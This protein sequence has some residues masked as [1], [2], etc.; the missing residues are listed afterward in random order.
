MAA[1]LAGRADADLDPVTP[2]HPVY[3]PTPAYWPHPAILNAKALDILSPNDEPG[4]RIDR[5]TGHIHGL[6]I[7]NPTKLLGTIY[8][9]VPMPGPAER[10]EAMVQAFQENLTYG[11]TAGYEAHGN[12]FIPD[13]Q[14]LGARLPHRVVAAYDVPRQGVETWM[15]ELTTGGDDLFRV[16]GVTVGVDGP[17]QFGLSLMREP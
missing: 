4:L 13:L 17:P 12:G 8:Q 14:A 7:F 5:T 16:D 3:I 15:A 11:I 9:H 1:V 6:H 2:D 10:Q